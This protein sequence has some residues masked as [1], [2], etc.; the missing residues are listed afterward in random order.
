MIP[1]VAAERLRDAVRIAH[2]QDVVRDLVAQ[3]E[4]L[5]GACGATEPVAQLRALDA[6]ARATGWLG[7]TPDLRQARRWAARSAGLARALR[8]RVWQAE[9]MLAQGYLAQAG[10]GHDELAARALSQAV[11]L[12]P[13]LSRQRG[14]VLTLLAEP[15]SSRPPA[16]AGRR[17]TGRC[18]PTRLLPT[19]GGMPRPPASP[20]RT[21][22]C[23]PAACAGG[24]CARGRP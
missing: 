19:S 10:T 15:G 1:E 12:L 24:R 22:P 11:D 16:A 23:V 3:G 2:T 7:T 6:L 5:L 4:R 14:R 13:G 17:T 21:I 9:A 8:R 18:V 20:E